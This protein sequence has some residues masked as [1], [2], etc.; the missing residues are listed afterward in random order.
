VVDELS[1]LIR[2]L[3]IEST[4]F[5]GFDRQASLLTRSPEG[6]L[7]FFLLTCIGQVV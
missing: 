3:A 2:D 7:L 5:N 1:Q 4:R 6:S